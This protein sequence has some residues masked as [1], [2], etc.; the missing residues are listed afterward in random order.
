MEV[1][2]LPAE[3]MAKMQGEGQAGD[4]EVHRRRRPRVR[5]RGLRRGRAG[6]REELIDRRRSSEQAE[7]RM[8]APTAL[9]GRLFGTPEAAAAFSDAARLQ[10]MLD[11]EAALARGQAR[12][13][14]DPG[15]RRARDR[16]PGPGPSC[17]TSAELGRGRGRGPAIPAIPLVKRLTALV[18]EHDEPAARFVHWGATS[19][20][21]MDTGLVL[22]LRA[23]LGA[24]RRRPRPAGG[25]AGPA[26]GRTHRQTPMVGRTWLQQA[27]PI[28]LRPQ[29]RGLAG[30]G[31]APPG[32]AGGAEAAAAGA[33]S[34]AAR[35]A[36]WRRWAS[37]GSTVA[38]A[39]AGELGL[40]AAGAALARAAR[41][42]GGARR[43]GSGCSPARSARSARDCVAA[44]ADR[45]RRGARA[46]RR[47]PGRLLDHAAQAQPGRGRRRAGRGRPARPAWSPPCSRRWCRSTSAG[48]AAGTPSGR[49]CPSWP[50]WPP[51]R[52]AGRPRRCEGL[53]VDAGADA[54]QPRS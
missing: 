22:Q 39:L 51:A 36:R 29:G 52:C 13:G 40:A 35:P 54:R 17:S 30:R 43:P 48:W 33:C 34:S 7:T 41:P 24:A 47:G 1:S 32:A 25:G 4:R 21:A 27:L 12:A 28:D 19:Q 6:A 8:S 16:R 44:D 26:G 9:L 42:G 15:R 45:G 18:A 31:R 46:G 50:C 11:F 14:R 20:D 37:R 3:E 5:G 10:G 53:E 38:E 49:R 2:E 23:F